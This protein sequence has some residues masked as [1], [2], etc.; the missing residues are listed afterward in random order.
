MKVVETHVETQ[1]LASLRGTHQ[2]VSLD[3]HINSHG[4]TGRA[5]NEQSK[6]KKPEAESFCF[7]LLNF[8][9]LLNYEN[10]A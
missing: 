5:K 6:T 4:L 10:T 2:L 7:R 3:F 8:T 9:T 1:D